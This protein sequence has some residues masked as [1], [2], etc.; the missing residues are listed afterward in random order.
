MTKRAGGETLQKDK[1]NPNKWER[2]DA[3]KLIKKAEKLVAMQGEH[4]EASPRKA[5]KI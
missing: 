4:T 5:L 1:K 2:N 3:K